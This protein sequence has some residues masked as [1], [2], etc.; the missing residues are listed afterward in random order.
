MPMFVQIIE[1]K[2]S[3]PAVFKER[4]DAWRRDLK[5]GATG[6]LGSTGGVTPDGRAIIIARFESRKAADANSARPEQGQW[7]AETEKAFDG[8]VTFRD[9]DDVDV[10]FDGGSNDAGFVQVI[11]G[12][13]K[14]QESFRKMASEHEAELR[15]AR[16]DILGML[17]AWH[18]DGGFSQ[19]VYFRDE[20]GTRKL[21][22]A[23]EG[24]EMRSEFM[25]QFEGQ[26]TFFDLTN[27]DLD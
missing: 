24:E 25:D 13:V 6:Y 9:C 16:P 20:A 21:E 14:D 10:V 27:P 19:A 2:V 15:Q 5:P 7:W 3:N 8:A 26:P 18:G 1:G 23:T 17:V 12:R 22:E 11:Q 4:S